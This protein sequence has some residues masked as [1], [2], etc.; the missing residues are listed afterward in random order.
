MLLTINISIAANMCTCSINF[1]SMH[2]APYCHGALTND[3]EYIA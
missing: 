3:Y 1:D 2:A